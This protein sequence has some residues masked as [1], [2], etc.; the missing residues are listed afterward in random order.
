MGST[1]WADKGI[2]ALYPNYRNADGTLNS[3]EYTTEKLKIMT[4]ANDLTRTQKPEMFLRIDRGQTDFFI[5]TISKYESAQNIYTIVSDIENQYNV[6]ETPVASLIVE[7]GVI[8]SFKTYKAFQAAD[9]KDLDG[10][11]AVKALMI[12]N[13]V[14]LNGTANYNIDVSS[15]LPKDNNLYEVILE[16]V[17]ETNATTGSLVNL[18]FVGYGGF[19]S[20]NGRIRTQSNTIAT[21]A[22]TSIQLIGQDRKLSLI[23]TTELS[24]KTRAWLRGYRKVR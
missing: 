11:W 8:T 19:I 17:G 20:T 18:S 14:S 23:R 5:S 16:A 24:G 21:C 3:I 10:G 13:N 2:K 6:N 7:N 9:A 15:Y 22:G 4:F 12:L 1:T